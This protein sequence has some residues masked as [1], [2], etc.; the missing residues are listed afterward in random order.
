LAYSFPTHEEQEKIAK[1]F[2]AMS[3][4]GF[5]CVVGAIDGLLIWTLMPPLFLCRM[6]DCGQANFRCHRKDKYG[7]NMIAICDH[8]LRFRW[9]DMNWPGATSNYMAWITSKLCMDLEDNAVTNVLRAGMTLVGDNAFVK[10]LFM[11]IPLRG[12]R[13]GYEDAYN[14]YHSQLRITIERSFGVFVH[15]W[16]ILRAPLTIPLLKV[17]PLIEC[18][19]RLHNYCIYEKEISIDTVQRKYYSNLCQNLLYSQH[20]GGAAASD[21]V[22]DN[23]KYHRPVELLDNGHHFHDSTEY[24]FDK[25]LKDVVTPMDE[26]L[27]LCKANDL[28]RPL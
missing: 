4:A 24:R 14:F 3:G 23:N 13:G 16:A 10:R 11:A 9:V 27:E 1:G 21:G 18:L 19:V 15:R 28:R 20:F 25:S 2:Y 26:M 6:I 7:C 22:V 5:K 8:T 12:I 17:A